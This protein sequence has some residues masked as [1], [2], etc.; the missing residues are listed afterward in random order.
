M[1]R[2]EEGEPLTA[3]I[4]NDIY[5]KLNE[6]YFG[7]GVVIDKGDCAG[8]VEDP[9]FLHAVL[10]VPV[11]HRIFGGHR[12]QPEDL[13]RGRGGKRGIHEVPERRKF[14]EPDRSAPALRRR[15]DHK[16]AG[17]IRVKAVWRAAG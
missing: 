3:E 14:H 15:H 5:Y 9:A 10:C 12:Y 11:R 1:R 8:V 4:L 16:G 2:P 6:Q 17:G 7:D 13:K